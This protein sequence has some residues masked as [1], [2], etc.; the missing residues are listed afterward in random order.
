MKK[1]VSYIDTCVENNVNKGERIKEKRHL[2]RNKKKEY[3]L[4]DNCLEKP[5]I[6][7]S[8]SI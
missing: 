8:Y 1:S 5:L 3:S 2:R 7:I 6:P 4:V